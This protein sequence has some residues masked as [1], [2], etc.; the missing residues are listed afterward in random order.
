MAAVRAG[1]NRVAIRNVLSGRYLSQSHKLYNEHADYAAECKSPRQDADQGDLWDI[2]FDASTESW[3]FRNVC[4]RLVLGSARSYAKSLHREFP[5]RKR[6][7]VADAGYEDRCVFV[8]GAADMPGRT[9][10][11]IGSVGTCKTC[12]QTLRLA[13]P[14]I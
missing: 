7:R 8:G 5:R 1:W 4:S 9:R 10:R 6:V 13:I 2:R 12:S 3:M 11:R 14:H